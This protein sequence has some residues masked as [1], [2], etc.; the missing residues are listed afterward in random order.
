MARSEASIAAANHWGNKSEE[1]VAD[2]NIAEPDT[3]YS[4][5]EVIEIKSEDED[6]VQAATLSEGEE[7]KGQVSE[8]KE[9]MKNVSDKPSPFHLMETPS[10]KIPKDGLSLEQL[11]SDKTLS[12]TFQFNF[13]IQVPFFLH[14][15]AKEA[16]PEITF[17]TGT[18]NLLDDPKLIEDKKLI[19]KYKISSLVAHVHDMFGSHHTKLMVNF[20]E[21][22]SKAEIIISSANITILDYGAL[23]QMCW[24]SGKLSKGK[25]KSGSQGEIFQRDLIRYLRKYRLGPVNE[26]AKKLNEFDFSSVEVELFASAPGTYDMSFVTDDSEVYGYG[27]LYQILKRNKITMSR[28]LPPGAV[29]NILG[30]VSSIASPWKSAKGDTASVLTHIIC[31]LLFHSKGTFVPLIP[32]S[33]PSRASQMFYK[34]KPLILYPTARDLSRSE[35]GWSAGQATHFNYTGSAPT[36]AQYKQNIKP[37]LYGWDSDIRSGAPAHVKMYLCDNADNWKTLKWAMMCSH[38]LSKQAWGYPVPGTDK[39]KRGVYRVAS[40]EL[41]VFVCSTKEK[42]LKPVKTTSG[43]RTDADVLVPFNLPPSRYQPEDQPWSYRESFKGLKDI[44]GREYIGVD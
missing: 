35:I 38:N 42:T 23:T 40:Y 32:G 43:A 24:R 22:D 39:T 16:S 1:N 37:Y 28:D 5:N 44:Y 29:Y 34:Y 17:I 14:H 20:F 7:S 36:R 6:G 3:D 33:Q 10:L 31:P 4:D 41:G 26:M 19:S 18:E 21:N 2:S 9:A 13:T 25:T 12:S 11:I 15:I 30:Q 27:K 8:G